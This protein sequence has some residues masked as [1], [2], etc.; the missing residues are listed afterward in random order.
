MREA[1]GLAAACVRPPLD[2]PEQG[3]VALDPEAER[4]DLLLTLAREGY[5]GKQYLYARSAEDAP[6]L[7]QR[8]LAL[9]GYYDGWGA[10]AAELAVLWQDRFDQAAALMRLYDAMAPGVLMRAICS[11]KVNYEGLER[12]ELQ[13]YLSM[14]GLGEDAH[15]D[16]FFDA[17]VNE[18]FAAF[19]QALGYAQLA[20]L[21]RSLSADLGA[22]YRED[23][24]LAQYLSYGPAYGDLLRERMDVWADAQVD[25]G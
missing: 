14:Y 21:M 18:P 22:A 24:A 6:G 10:Y 19:P 16:F 17:A 2:A 9:P 20:D 25:K 7:M 4:A 13:E 15:V 12:G 11:I 8:A 23:E 3:A 5:P 1:P